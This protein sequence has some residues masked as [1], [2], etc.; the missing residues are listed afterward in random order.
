MIGITQPPP[1]D[2]ARSALFSNRC[3]RHLHK[4]LQ[5]PSFGG[6]FVILITV[7]YSTVWISQAAF[8]KPSFLYSSKS[9]QKEGKNGDI[10]QCGTLEK[11][12]ARHNI[13]KYNILL[14]FHQ[15]IYSDILSKCMIF[16]KMN[17]QI[18]TW[19]SAAFKIFTH[20]F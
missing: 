2:S 14:Y 13:K 11:K 3:L 7:P 20:E 4:Q 8:E 17:D 15:S 5:A 10:F 6:G 19:I 9:T 1:K 16:I 18:L 12:S